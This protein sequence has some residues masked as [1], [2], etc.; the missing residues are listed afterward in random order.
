MLAWSKLP[1]FTEGFL[2]S[3][4]FI[5]RRTRALLLENRRAPIEQRVRDC[6]CATRATE[7]PA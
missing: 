6:A 1:P 7:S 5:S 2:K 4:W 3:P